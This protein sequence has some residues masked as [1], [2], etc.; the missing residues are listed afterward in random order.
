MSQ[1]EELANALADVTVD[2]FWS[3]VRWM[4]RTK[5]T[6]WAV[7]FEVFSPLVASLRE[8]WNSASRPGMSVILGP[9]TFSVSWATKAQRT[10]R[11]EDWGVGIAS[12]ENSLLQGLSTNQAVVSLMDNAAVVYGSFVTKTGKFGDRM[13]V[14]KV[15]PRQFLSP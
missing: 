5:W 14:R 13:V 12:M 15:K 11:T 2:P 1:S 8:G 3:E 9:T 7:G 6:R 4:V 10:H